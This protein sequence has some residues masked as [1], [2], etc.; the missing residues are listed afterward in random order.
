MLVSALGRPA[1]GTAQHPADLAAG[2]AG[3]GV[4]AEMQ[5]R[6]EIADDL[7]A[8]VGGAAAGEE[9][10]DAKDLEATLK[11]ALQD[12]EAAAVAA[13]AIAAAEEKQAEKR[14]RVA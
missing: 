11:H 3:A 4:L 10:V 6:R 13:A 5:A 14:Q 8:A 7:A 12:E 9:A 2:A 1:A